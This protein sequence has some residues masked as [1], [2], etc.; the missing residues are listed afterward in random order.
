MSVRQDAV[1]RVSQLR[2]LTLDEIADLPPVEWL[3]EG[4]LPQDGL[5]VIY[6]EPRIGKTFIALDWALSLA[7]G[8]EWLGN[9]IHC[10]EVVYIY[11]EG[12]RGLKQRCDAWL[13][14][15]GIDGFPENF[16]AI[17]CPVNMLDG[18][19][20]S[21]L[22]TA[23]N[24]AGVRPCL[25]VIDTLARCFGTGDENQTKDMTTFVAGC[26]DL[27]VEHFP[28]ATVLVVHHTGKNTDRGA[29][30]SIALTDAADVEFLVKKSTGE[31]ISL[32]NTKQ[33]DGALLPDLRLRRVE[34]RGSCVI[35]RA[36]AAQDT[37]ANEPEVKPGKGENTEQ[38]VFFSLLPYGADGATY[39]QWLDASGKSKRTF[40]RHRKSLVDA[41]RVE[42]RGGRY[43]CTVR[44]GDPWLNTTG[45]HGELVD[46]SEGHCEH[47]A[48]GLGSEGSLGSLTL[49]Q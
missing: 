16:R 47:V 10:G 21:Y 43:F 27:R 23:I 17:P 29:R 1:R 36:T 49:S 6:G 37:K 18:T 5:G 22:V 3:I 40:K 42:Q 32:R 4:H 2:P 41:R 15:R 24:E 39:S 26:D 11:A 35:R 31:T 9:R 20:R 45:E 44:I 13:A 33:K 34:V 46:P 14:E 19:D 30:G 38:E 48:G 28:G 12:V 8:T 7:S 25:I